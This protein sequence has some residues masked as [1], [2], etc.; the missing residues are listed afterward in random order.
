MDAKLIIKYID[1]FNSNWFKTPTMLIYDS[2]RSA[3]KGL[4]SNHTS[5]RNSLDNGKLFR[6]RY[7]ITSVLSNDK[8]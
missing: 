2:L 8:S 1:Y 7:I 4:N 3:G 5:M 6:D